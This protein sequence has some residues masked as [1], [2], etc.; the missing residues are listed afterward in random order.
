MLYLGSLFI[1]VVKIFQRQI[2]SF[3]KILPIMSQLLNKSYSLAALMIHGAK[4]EVT[5]EKI[6]AVFAALNLEYSSKVA[7]MFVLSSEKYDSMLTSTGAA[8]AAP[9][10]TGASQ[11]AA[12]EPEDE[13]EESSE[14]VMAF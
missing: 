5:V 1:F 10:T 14:G 13:K 6:K 7:S 12:P 3:V 9:A 8:A 4:Q 2:F 11:A